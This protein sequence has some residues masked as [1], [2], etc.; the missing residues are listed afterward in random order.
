MLALQD[1]ERKRPPRG[2]VRGRMRQGRR[3]R[4]TSC[5][6]IAVKRSKGSAARYTSSL[7]MERSAGAETVLGRVLV[8]EDDEAARHGVAAAL[9]AR[10]HE[11]V[12][13]E[14]C[15]DALRLFESRP[16]V[17]ITDLRL[18]DGDAVGL[19]PQ[20]RAIDPSIPV[21]IITGFAT[22]DVAVR[23]VKLGAEE[24]FTKPVE[25]ATLL[26]C[27]DRAM[28][29]RDARKSG[30]RSRLEPPTSDARTLEE[31]EREHIVRSLEA[32]KGRVRDTARR[33]GIPRSTLYQKIKNYG[34][35]LPTR[36]RATSAAATSSTN[37]GD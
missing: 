32:E 19:L 12:E 29:Q 25:M 2:L 22:I 17:V 21:Y 8:V 23:A 3:K 6:R 18:P 9:R 30:Q 14:C 16:D 15:G 24:F 7:L 36:A 37:N 20:L 34:I 26:G 11:V 1:L 33:L 13:A 35:A 28:E 27:V 10:H 4:M 31:V 5:T